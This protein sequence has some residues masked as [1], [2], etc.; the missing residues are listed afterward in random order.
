[1]LNIVIGTT[2]EIKLE[3][4][5]QACDDLGISARIHPVDVSS[6]INA[7]P[8]GLGEIT[9]GATNRC[10]AARTLMP[11]NDYAIG[12]ENGIDERS[13]GWVDSAVIEVRGRTGGRLTWYSD[14]VPF[15]PSAVEEAKRRGFETTTVSQVLAEQTKCSPT[16]PH[17]YLTD[18]K[19]PRQDIL[20]RALVGALK[21]LQSC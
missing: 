20:R 17:A 4:L 12:I 10:L 13:E 16:D 21:H 11:Q 1:M 18:G 15:P 7:Q 6:G 2:N 19:H 8:V 5:R 9:R 14:P 3:A